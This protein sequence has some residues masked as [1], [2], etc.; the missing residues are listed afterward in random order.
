[1]LAVHLR[2]FHLMPRL[3]LRQLPQSTSRD[4]LFQKFRDNDFQSLLTDAETAATSQTPPS[5]A[6]AFKDRIR[7][8]IKDRR[9]RVANQSLERLAPLDHS[10]AVLH[11]LQTKFPPRKVELS[12]R[13]PL[14]VH[15]LLLTADEVFTAA[16]QVNPFSGTGP[17]A[18]SMYSLVAPLRAADT[19]DDVVEYAELLAF[20]A[21]QVLNGCVHTREALSATKLIALPKPDGGIRPIN[22]PEA[23]RRLF[24]RIISNRYLPAIRR[25]LAPIQLGLAKNGTDV[26]VHTMR[27][28][29]NANPDSF[30]LC[31]DFSNAF[32]EVSRAQ[33]RTAL[34][35]YFPQLLP[36][37]DLFHQHE[38]NVYFHGTRIAAAE[39]TLQ[40]DNWGGM[41]FA[42]AIHP[43]LEQLQAD[44]PE[45]QLQ[46]YFDDVS[47]LG[48]AVSADRLAAFLKAFAERFFSVGL[49][50]NI[51]KCQ[52]YAPSCDLSQWASLDIFGQLRTMSWD[53]TTQVPLVTDPE[54]SIH[55]VPP[56]EG[57][58]FLGTP[59]G[60]P[61]W[62]SDQLLQKLAVVRQN[63][64][65]LLLI[66][67]LPQEFVLLLRHCV[68]NQLDHL[69]RTVPPTIL[70]P[71]AI[72]FDAAVHEL[73]CTL[74]PQLSDSSNSESYASRVLRAPSRFGGLAIPSLAAK[75]NAA[76][77]ASLC[78]ALPTLT[79]FNLAGP[80]VKDCCLTLL[81]DFL[82]LLTALPRQNSYTPDILD[83]HAAQ[84]LKD[85]HQIL[86]DF[87]FAATEW[88]NLADGITCHSERIFEHLSRAPRLQNAF[89]R[90]LQSHAYD[91]LLSELYT[92]TD[93]DNFHRCARFLSRSCRE[94]VMWSIAIPTCPQLT[95][96]PLEYRHLLAFTLDFK[97]PAR[98]LMPYKCSCNTF[99]DKNGYHVLACW[100]T[101]MHD[102]TV[103]ELHYFARSAGLVSILEPRH[104]CQGELRPDLAID[105]LC[106][107]GKTLLLDFTTTDPASKDALCHRQS[108]AEINAAATHAESLKLQKYT[109]RFDAQEFAFSPLSMELT[110]RWSSKLHSVFSSIKKFAVQSGFRGHSHWPQY[111]NYWRQRISVQF[112]KHL[113]GSGIYISTQIT[114]DTRAS[115]QNINRIVQVL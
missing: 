46:A 16:R 106:D 84:R 63:L 109:G 103:R 92:K 37:F 41:F 8:L 2:L 96:S 114:T 99:L 91:A 65:R 3:L 95:V 19:Q 66:K 23:S 78:A 85:F 52:I 70:R 88:N 51:G 44:F 53:N 74:I 26:A 29:L 45:F 47:V 83:T 28:H 40:G 94:A 38:T 11:K 22:I 1:M 72:R 34:N 113:A 5:K 61:S 4:T 48:R 101:R 20:Y 59:L 14:R 10:P 56:E 33:I 39:G 17:S 55:R 111:V 27:T 15:A 36:F 79:H 90:I 57:L 108:Y 54:K 35:N 49:Q 68:V 30:A 69:A 82:P 77:L 7:Q 97:L 32:N 9:L 18:M 31:L 110:G 81:A 107:N 6:P 73:M 87:N 42:I 25:R 71:I 75:L 60:H 104:T 89:I 58:L 43:L 98:R 24:S 21:T 64:D 62:V 13:R 80:D 100:R 86:G 12:Q 105:G 93:A 102:R 76:Y 50:L 67:D 115:R 112:A